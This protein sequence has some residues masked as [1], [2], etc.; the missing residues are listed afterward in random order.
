MSFSSLIR[1]TE[2]IVIDFAK[3]L[4]VI[5]PGGEF[6]GHRLPFCGIPYPE[7]ID[8]TDHNTRQDRP[9]RND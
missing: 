4:A 3:A 1:Q 8:L 5:C 9:D 7:T 2:S 6:A